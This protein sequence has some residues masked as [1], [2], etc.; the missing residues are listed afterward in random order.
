MA[1]IFFTSEIFII[2]II[3]IFDFPKNRKIENVNNFNYKISVFVKISN[4]K[5]LRRVSSRQGFLELSQTVE[6]P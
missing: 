3:N 4:L 5:M 1:K 6:T 2:E